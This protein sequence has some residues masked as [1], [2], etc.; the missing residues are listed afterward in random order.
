MKLYETSQINGMVLKNRFV[1]SATWEGMAGDDGSTTSQL[2]DCMEALAHGGVGLIITSH[3]FVLENGRA[4]PKQLGVYNDDMIS[5]LRKMTRAVHDRG[6]KIGIQLNHAGLFAD[7][8]LTGETPYGPS[9][10][11]RRVQSP[12]KEMTP[13]H[14]ETVIEAF[15]LAARRAKQAGFDCVQIHGAHGYLISQFFSPAFNKRKDNYGGGIEKR[16]RIVVDVLERIRKYVGPRYP[17][18]VK[19]NSEDFLPSGLDLGDAIRVG[20][21]LKENGADAIE[22]SGGTIISGEKIPSRTA[23]SGKKNEAYYTD[24]AVAFKETIDLPLILVGGIRS[25][26]AAETILNAQMADYFSMSRPF[27]REPALINRWKSGDFAPSTCLS[28]NQCFAP[29]IAGEGIYCVMEKK[30]ADKKSKN[31]LF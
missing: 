28:D 11:D 22:L 23:I 25:F 30:L 5:G 12:H 17:V 27:I 13:D 31:Q 15:G 7:S 6:G 2:I 26:H 18:M 20:I 10:V 4:R 24:A 14:I 9:V 8:A 19:I 29:A 3:A 1:R 21:L 16:S